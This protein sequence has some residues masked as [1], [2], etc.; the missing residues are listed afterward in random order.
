MGIYTSNAD[1][2]VCP[3]CGDTNTHIDR[4]AMA[5]RPDGEDGMII[6]IAVPADGDVV[7]GGRNIPPS[8]HVGTGRRHRIA[9]IGWCESC[10]GEFAWLFTQHKGVTFLESID[11][12]ER[13]AA[14]EDAA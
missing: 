14:D 13:R 9:L 3:L 12:G 8:R 6:E 7:R 1:E 11:L 5:A 10:R 4:V 2:M